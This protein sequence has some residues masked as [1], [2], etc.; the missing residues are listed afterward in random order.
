MELL[1]STRSLLLARLMGARQIASESDQTRAFAHPDQAVSGNR[2]TSNLSIF[3]HTVSM[4]TS[5]NHTKGVSRGGP[6]EGFGSSSGT[7]FRSN[8][9][10]ARTVSKTLQRATLGDPFFMILGSGNA[11]GILKYR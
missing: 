4:L 10:N 11:H 8:D 9:L 6:L 5:C 7:Q 1:K 2:Q 3:H